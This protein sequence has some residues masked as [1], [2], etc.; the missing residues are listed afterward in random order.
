MVPT[1]VLV[2][3][4][5][6]AGQPLEPAALAEVVAA[7]QTACLGLLDVVRAVTVPAASPS[8][9][10]GRDLAPGLTVP[11]PRETAST[12]SPPHTASEEMAGVGQA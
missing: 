2:P 11:R 8:K 6:E 9:K 4:P 3:G 12:A 7:L 1:E 10:V 5:G